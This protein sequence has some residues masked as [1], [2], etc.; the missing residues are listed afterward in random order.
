M[1]QGYAIGRSSQD[2]RLVSILDKLSYIADTLDEALVE[3]R[4]IRTATSSLATESGRIKD[5]DLDPNS[6][7]FSQHLRS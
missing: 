2:K 4:V 1:A 5:A 6:V 7:D 3:L